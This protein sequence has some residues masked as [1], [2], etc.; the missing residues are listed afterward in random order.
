MDT[1]AQKI[2]RAHIAE[3]KP[4]TDYDRGLIDGL[5]MAIFLID[6]TRMED[7][8]RHENLPLQKSKINTVNQILNNQAKRLGD[9]TSENI[10]KAFSTTPADVFAAA[11]KVIREE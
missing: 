1:T 5:L 3:I 2:I 9:L 4:Q 6:E 11:N 10:S 8:I 7:R